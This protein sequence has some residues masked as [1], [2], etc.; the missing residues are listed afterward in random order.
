MVTEAL[1]NAAVDRAVQNLKAEIET[2]N[3]TDLTISGYCSMS[4]VARWKAPVQF[5]IELCAR[6]KGL[7][8]LFEQ[9]VY[10]RGRAAN[11]A[12][13]NLKPRR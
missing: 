9:S 6:Q 1:V 7:D 10:A 12:P 4:S 8:F 2:L 5:A 3:D 11:I 13:A